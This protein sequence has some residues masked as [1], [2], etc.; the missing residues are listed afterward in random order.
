MI[1][2]FLIL[3]PI[4][5]SSCSPKIRTSITENHQSL[6]QGEKV[7]VYLKNSDLPKKSIKIGSTRIGDTGFT[8]NCDYNIIL[9]KAKIEARKIGSNGI[10]ITEHI[11]PNVFGSSC[12]RINAD[13]YKIEIN[14]NVS[15]N[16]VVIDS[17]KSEKNSVVP[18]S[19]VIENTS[20]YGINK[21][22]SK[23]IVMSNVAQSFRIAET[24]DGLTSQQKKYVKQL[25]SGLSYDVS[26][27]YLVD[28]MRGYGLKYNVYRSNG[29]INNQTLTLQD[30]SIIRGSFSDDITITFI[31]P[32]F[33]LTDGMKSKIGEGNME[34][35]L[36]FMS[37][38]NNSIIINSPLKITGSNLGM[39]GGF[40]YHFRLTP[41]ILVGPQLNFIGGTLKKL[42]LKYE[43]GTTETVKLQD[44]QLENLWRI[45]LAIGAKFRF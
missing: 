36:G 3:I 13:L 27:Y 9:E 44:D 32:S 6:D 1:K 21:K 24:P 29:T 2:Y 16:M 5:L 18:K 15:E 8:V 41:N 42:K 17:I 35:A 11:L 33:I 25:K 43:N 39:I 45:D 37:Y 23:F 19:D 4:V 40:G 10:L 30:N 7:E 12:H 14:N 20:K 31:G 28:S 34:V 38:Q 22:A 26:A